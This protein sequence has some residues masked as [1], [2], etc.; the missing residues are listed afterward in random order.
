[1]FALEGEVRGLAHEKKIV[2]KELKLFAETQSEM[3]T[4][5]LIIQDRCSKLPIEGTDGRVFRSF[6]FV[7]FSFG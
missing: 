1:V 4:Q 3:K 7:L 5:A 2:S 6:L